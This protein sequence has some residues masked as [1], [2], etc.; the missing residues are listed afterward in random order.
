MPLQDVEVNNTMLSSGLKPLNA[1]TSF[2][3]D[4]KKRKELSDGVDSFFQ[5]TD[6][7]SS[8]DDS[9]SVKKLK[10]VEIIKSESVKSKDINTS[11]DESILIK[12]PKKILSVTS[13]KNSVNEYSCIENKTGSRIEGKKI[14]ITG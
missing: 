4:S 10:P 9:I 7:K 6:T 12:S 1:K 11:I 3:S 14:V 2:L 8:K 5:S 13:S